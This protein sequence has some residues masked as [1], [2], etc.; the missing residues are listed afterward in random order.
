M[1][2]QNIAKSVEF[3]INME[4]TG[5][6]TLGLVRMEQEWERQSGQLPEEAAAKDY[7]H[8]SY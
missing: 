1:D 5:V 6:E 3:C 4:R 8:N 7:E 2:L